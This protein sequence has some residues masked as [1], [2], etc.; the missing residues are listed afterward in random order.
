MT[1]YRWIFISSQQTLVGASH[2]CRA[3]RIII[4]KLRHLSESK[5]NLKKYDYPV[6]IITNGIK[7]SLEIPQKELRK[8]KEK[9]TDEV[10]PFISTFNLNIPAVYSTIKNSV[11]VLKGNNV[12]GFERIKLINI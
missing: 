5:E 10:L 1:K 8:S 9:Q 7:K 2:S 4:I 11:E 12:S 6:N 3:T